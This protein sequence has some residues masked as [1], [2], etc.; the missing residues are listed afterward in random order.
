[1]VSIA[2]WA[3]GRRSFPAN[4]ASDCWRVVIRRSLLVGLLHVS[5]IVPLA[6]FSS[7]DVK[8]ATHWMRLGM[9][10]VSKGMASKVISGKDQIF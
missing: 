4:S 10:S 7:A 2:S 1:M 8:P 9:V 5:V 6:L 3:A